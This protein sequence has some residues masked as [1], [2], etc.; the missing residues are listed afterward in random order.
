MKVS[1]ILELV[2]AVKSNELSDSVKIRWLC[3]VEG[4]ILCEIHKKKPE[5]IKAI[6]GSEDILSVPGPYSRLY[7]FYLAAM[8]DF[9]SGDSAAFARSNVAFEKAFEESAKYVLR[10]R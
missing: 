3:D 2:D 1:E 5:E 10:S 6:K 4:R 8:I 7:L 9:S